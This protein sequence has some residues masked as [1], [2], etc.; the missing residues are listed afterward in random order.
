MLAGRSEDSL[1]QLAEETSA[2][3]RVCDARHFDQVKALID[4]TVESFGRVDGIVNCAG[5]L[6]LKPAHLTSEDEFRDVID[7]NLTTA[8][9]VVKAAARAM[10]KDGG[11]IVLVSSAVA[12]T[13]LANHEAIAAAKAGVGGLVRSAAATYGA[14]KVRVNCVAPGLVETPMTSRI[15]ANESARS[16]SASM[17]ALGSIG[18][19][20]DLAE[21]IVWLLDGE[22]SGWVTGQEIGVDGGLGTVRPR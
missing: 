17:H 8:F 5:S 15:T 3:W 9:C 7:T 18:T 19:P 21:P 14:R 4:S 13:G 20:G 12:R 1:R 16:Q 6:L 11:S 22:R 10:M 2:Q